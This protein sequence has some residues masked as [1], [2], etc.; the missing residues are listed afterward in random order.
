MKSTFLTAQ[1][2]INLRTRF[3]LVFIVTAAFSSLVIALLIIYNLDQQIKQ[4]L[5]MRA[6][7][8]AILA[9]SQ[10]NGD[11]HSTLRDASQQDG[12]VYTTIRRKNETVM[13]ADRDISSVYTMRIQNDGGVYYVVDVINPN[14]NPGRKTPAVLGEAANPSPI[15]QAAI[16]ATVPAPV[17][18]NTIYEDEW[19]PSLSGYAPFYRNNGTLE[20]WVGV[21]IHASALYEI[22]N[23]VIQATVIGFVLLTILLAALGW[24]L[25]GRVSEPLVKI[26]QNAEQIA[27]GKY[28]METITETGGDEIGELAKTFNL[29]TANVKT[30]VLQ[31]EARVHERTIELETQTNELSSYLKKEAQRSNQFQTIA[32]VGR[33]I[34]SIR[35]IEDPLRRITEIVSSQFGFYHVGIFLMSDDGQYA[36]LRATNSEGGLRMLARNHRLRVG[37]SGL[38]GYVANT[39]NARIALDTGSDAVF[40]NNPDLPET[41]SEAALPLRTGGQII[42]VLDVQSSQAAAFNQGDIELLSILAD[43]VSVAIQNARLFEETRKSL[44]EAEGFYLQYLRSEWKKATKST[45]KVG[46]R[47][48]LAG[49]QPIEKPLLSEEINQV[50]KT[51]N[52]RTS[53]TQDDTAQITIPI[54]L[55]NEVIGV[56][57]VKS[58]EKRNWSEDEVDI[59]SSIAN[60]IAIAAENARLLSESQKRA[61]KERAISQIAAKISS[62][63]SMDT[64]LQTAVQE[65]GKA[66]PVSDVVIH[67]RPEEL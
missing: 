5:Q 62:S 31:L 46:Y 12:S 17:V 37:E 61:N 39:G 14:L 4:Q 23:Q 58:Y 36:V 43:Q 67:M 15:L 25:G 11:L 21:D 47:Y 51:G 57:S 6:Q 60:R 29:M 26:S 52:V 54:K 65:L 1:G 50:I 64:I 33:L 8:F 49:T 45:Q 34:T 28:E 55:R 48:S 7:G 35:D 13:L 40:F 56:I 41:R 10:L 59:A 24:W 20:G 22:R 3:A 53:E 9:A 2:A 18:E 32:Q 30:L 63:T 16:E 42:G 66:L 44:A 27:S 19:G 38:V